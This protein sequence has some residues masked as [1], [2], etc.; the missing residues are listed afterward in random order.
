MINYNNL[1]TNQK[2]DITRALN[3]VKARKAAE[4][5]EKE[6]LAKVFAMVKANGAVVKGEEKITFVAQPDA[7]MVFDYKRFE[8]EHPG[9]VLDYL[10]E[11]AGAKEHLTTTVR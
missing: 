3:A 8:T 9:I 4:K 5:A 2:T 6:A 1:T 10:T 11:K 7:K